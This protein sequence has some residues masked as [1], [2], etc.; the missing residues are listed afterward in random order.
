MYY[1]KYY[2][3]GL[4]GINH[5]NFSNEYFFSKLRRAT[6]VNK[7]RYIQKIFRTIKGFQ[8]IVR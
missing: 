5:R 3:R 2:V 1:S 8:Q 6:G 7:D 4:N